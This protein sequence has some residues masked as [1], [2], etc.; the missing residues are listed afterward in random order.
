MQKA[1][2]VMVVDDDRD[3]LTIM[4]YGLESYEYQVRACENAVEALACASTEAFDF[5]I[6][7]HDMPCMDGID[8]TRRLRQSLPAAVI[9]G[10][11]G[12]DHGMAFLQAG[13]NDFL[14]KPF[15]P[16]DVIMMIDGGDMPQ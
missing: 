1:A 4:V 12:R 14:Q 16:H 10:M 6:V 8:L 11:S 9:I 3:V 13:A 7:D 2:K 15:A 5:I